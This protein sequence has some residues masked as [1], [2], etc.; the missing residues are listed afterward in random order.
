MRTPAFIGGVLAPANRSR[1]KAWG[2]EYRIGRGPKRDPPQE[3]KVAQAKLFLKIWLIFVQQENL[4]W[5]YAYIVF[6]YFFWMGGISSCF[7]KWELLFWGGC[8][9][10]T[11]HPMC[12]HVWSRPCHDQVSGVECFVN[13]DMGQ[14]RRI[15]GGHGY[16][17]NFWISMYKWLNFR[18]F[19]SSVTT[20][21]QVVE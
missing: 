11:P 16:Q 17:V 13:Q 15:A 20:E 19:W 1:V 21:R 7:Y 8:M 4:W 2:F 12:A 9:E 14:E 5:G 18:P 10:G 3:K 6:L